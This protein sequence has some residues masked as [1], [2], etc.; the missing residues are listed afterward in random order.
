M[1]RKKSPIEQ[2]AEVMREIKRRIEVVDY[3]LSGPGHALYRPT[4]TESV[5][6]QIR[7][8]LELIAMASLVANKELYAKVHKDF[9]RHWNAELMLK[10]LE[11]LNPKFYP[12]PIKEVPSSKPR[13]QTEQVELT[14]GFLTKKDFVKVYKKCGS[15]LHADNP[16]GRKS[17]YNFFEVELPLWR[18]W[19]IKL[20]NSHIV[21]L[22]GSDGFWLIH[23][24][25]D[26][27][28]EVHFYEFSLVRGETG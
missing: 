17:N 22:V 8:I 3:F 23:M 11:R 16:L 25:E 7:K 28:N 14:D 5:C 13:I 10:D 26:G 4:T 6:L 2:Y 1:K 15:L 24:Q 19:L 27:D 21:K 12:T 18:D 20:L 9:A